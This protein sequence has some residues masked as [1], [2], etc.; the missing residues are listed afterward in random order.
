M[1]L[2]GNLMAEARSWE[3]CKPLNVVSRK[4]FKDME[5]TCGACTLC[6]AQMSGFVWVGT[7]EPTRIVHVC[8]TVNE[9]EKAAGKPTLREMPK[10]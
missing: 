2:S 9:R 8:M 10:I 3:D 5:V 1:N 6:V 7:E 4:G